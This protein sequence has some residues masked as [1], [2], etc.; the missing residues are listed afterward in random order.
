MMFGDMFYKRINNLSNWQ[1]TLFSLVIT[2]RMYP[3]LN[4][5]SESNSLNIHT[6]FEKDLE[7]LWSYLE[8]HEQ[9]ID[10][11]ELQEQLLELTPEYNEEDPLGKIVASLAC[12]SLLITFD[13]ILNHT[14]TEALLVSEKSIMTVI[15]YLEVRDDT[16]YD[17][18]QIVELDEIQAEL[19]F[20]MNIIEV[21]DHK[22]SSLMFKTLKE[23]AYNEG[24]SNI[25][26]PLED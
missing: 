18:D 24:F 14:K 6:T 26:I 23:M 21:L 11:A 13:S 15:K 16:T 25:G 5:Y 17:E 22:R 8:S 3:N 9:Q 7:L 2:V 1:Q 20:Q 10:F 4:L 12:Q 19:D